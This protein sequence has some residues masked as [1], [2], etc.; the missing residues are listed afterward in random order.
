METGCTGRTLRRSRASIWRWQFLLALHATT[1]VAARHV[2][3]TLSGA[4]PTLH[5]RHILC[6]VVWCRRT[7]LSPPFTADAINCH[8]HPRVKYAYIYIYIYMHICIYIY[9][10]MYI[11]IYIYSHLFMCLHITYTCFLCVYI[12]IYIHIYIYIYIYVYI[13]AC[14]CIYIY[15]YTYTPTSPGWVP[16]DR[17]STPSASGSST[18]GSSWR[19]LLLLTVLL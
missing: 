3:T 2:T 4:L 14:V 15:I 18:T 13:H 11:Y 6:L 12:Y 1:T 17:S 7:K 8:Q 5:P 19:T 10:Y 16:Y 9:I